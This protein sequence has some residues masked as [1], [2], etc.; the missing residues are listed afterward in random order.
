MFR[1]VRDRQNHVK[2]THSW[3]EKRRNG[4]VSLNALAAAMQAAIVPAVEKRILA[5]VSCSFST[6]VEAS[7]DP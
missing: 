1:L 5:I 2:Y 4:D 6:S 3:F 7:K